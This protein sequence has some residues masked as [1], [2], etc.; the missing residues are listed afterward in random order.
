MTDTC[1]YPPC[2]K[3]LKHIEG[4]RK[5]KYCDAK[6]KL[7]HWQLLN[8]AKKELKTKRI[9]IKKWE[10]IQRKLLEKNDRDNPFTN[11]ARGRDA[12]G[13]NED[14]RKGILELINESSFEVE[15]S[16]KSRFVLDK[17]AKINQPNPPTTLDELKALCPFEKGTDEFRLWV[18]TER[19]KYGI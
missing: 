11:A 19:Q 18:Q 14:E 12:S 16:H 5:K 13:V 17:E 8:P 9:P 10:E 1:T 4:R 3:E 2:G 6:C 7:K 15:Y